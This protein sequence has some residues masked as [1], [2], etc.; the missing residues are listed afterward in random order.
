[1][2]LAEKNLRDPDGGIHLARKKAQLGILEVV[3]P[4][5]K[6]CSPNEG[7]S[8]NLEGLPE[9]KFET[10]WTYM[11]A[12]LDAKKQLLTAKPLVKGYNFYKSHNIQLF[13]MKEV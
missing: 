5:A 10:I 9:V 2:G 13:F 11:V 12:C 4:D 1:M 3:E 6:T 8:E 7:F